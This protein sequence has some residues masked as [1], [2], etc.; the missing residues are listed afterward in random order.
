MSGKERWFKDV[1]ELMVL[2]CLSQKPCYCYEIVEFINSYRDDEHKIEHNAV[3]TAL[4]F[5]QNRKAVVEE[6]IRVI[7]GKTRTYY[8]LTPAGRIYFEQFLRDYHIYIKTAEDVLEGSRKLS[9]TR[10]STV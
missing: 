1:D 8:N 9:D 3:Y 2:A 5:L 10:N 7:E 4:F 6:E